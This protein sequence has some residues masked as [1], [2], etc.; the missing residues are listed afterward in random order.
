MPTQTINIHVEDLTSTREL[1]D[2]IQV[3]RSPDESGSPTPF[4][5]VTA[6]TATKAIL[7]GTVEGPWNLN[8]LT[9]EITLNSADPQTM[10]FSGTNPFRL[11]DVLAAINT[12]FAGIAKEVPTDTERIRLESPLA[13]TGSNI[14][15]TGSAVAVL[16]FSTSKARGRGNRIWLTSPTTEYEFKDFDGLDTDWY[17]TRFYSS[18]SGA[19]SEFSEP[20]Q[21][22]VARVLPE[23]ALTSC[24][25]YLADAVGRPIVG[26]RVIL[27]PMSNVLV[28]SGSN[29][30][31]VLSSVDRI[32]AVTDEK[33]YAE[34]PL[35][36]GQTF[37]VFFEGTTI[38]RQFTVPSTGDTLNLLTVLS[39]SPDPFSIVV[40]PPLAVRVSS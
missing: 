8:G 15:V 34:T 7:D 39:T 36:K 5:E 25:V 12:L 1:Y 13:G 40:S 29:Q 11:V 10:V 14:Q 35:P 33:G 16:G 20:A 28:T 2:R 22:R 27:V 37:K 38:H 30:Y 18:V 19:V 24:F 4:T 17:K 9:L 26:R 32:V 6:A 21:G 23:S 3:W 31:G